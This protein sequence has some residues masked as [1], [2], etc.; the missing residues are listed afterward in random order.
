MVDISKDKF[1][2]IGA[3]A[4]ES[5]SIVRPSISYW[6]DAWRRLKMNKVAMASLVF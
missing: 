1:E 3:N 4:S 5:Q 2:I 6:Q